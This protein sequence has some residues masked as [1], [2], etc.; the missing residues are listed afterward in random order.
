M[1]AMQSGTS[2]NASGCR[3]PQIRGRTLFSYARYAARSITMEMWCP[4]FSIMEMARASKY[5]QFEAQ[6][7]QQNPEKE[8]IASEDPGFHSLI[9]YLRV[10]VRI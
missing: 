1:G 8:A 6:A 9:Q 2:F 7:E 4:Y 5:F 3:V 10:R